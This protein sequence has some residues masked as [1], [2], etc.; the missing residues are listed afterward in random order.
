MTIKLYQ[1]TKNN[2]FYKALWEAKDPDKKMFWYTNL[3]NSVEFI[4][5]KDSAVIALES[6]FICRSLI[7]PYPIN[8]L[9]INQLSI[10]KSVMGTGIGYCRWSQM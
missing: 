8:H 7:Q 2:F 5:K 4:L 10:H 3:S 6:G 1:S 9:A